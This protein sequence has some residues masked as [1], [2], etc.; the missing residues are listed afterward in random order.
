MKRL[1]AVL[2]CFS[3]LLCVTSCEEK[4]PSNANKSF[5]Y[6]LDAEPKTLDPQ[7]AND[8]SGTI[9]IQALFEGLTRLDADGNPTPGVAESW[10]SNHTFTEFTF[11][12]RQDAVWNDKEKTPVTADDFVYAFRRALDP[13]TGSTTSDPLLC[14]QNARAVRSGELP[15]EQLGVTAAGTHK[16]VVTL[17]YPYEDFPK[18]TASAV[19]MPCHEPFFESTKGRYG[20]EKS[21]LLGNGPFAIDGIYGWEHGSYINLRRFSGY[22]GDIKPLPSDIKFS[23]GSKKADVSDPIAALKDGTVDAI[24]MPAER[25]EEAREMGCTITRFEDT[26]WG[27]CFN[28]QNALMRNLNIRK[29]FT[30]SF[31]RAK[32]LSHLPAGTT[33]AEN[34][35]T[36][37]TKLFGKNYRE[38]AGSA[39][40]LQ[41]D[42]QAA[43]FLAAGIREL[44][45]ETL[46]K[47]TILCPDD[48]EVRL[49]VNEMLTEWNA[50]FDYYFNMESLSKKE[51]ASRIASGNYQLAICSITPDA[52][53]PLAVLNLF[54]SSSQNNPAGLRSAGYDEHLS[55]AEHQ[56]G[57]EAAAT[58]AAMERYLNEQCI[59]YPLYYESH[60][61]ASAPGVTGIVFHP[62]GGGVDFI[63]AGKG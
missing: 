19:C 5:Q 15:L 16:L 33:A 52:E 35:I 11:T 21:T 55:A 60:Y 56:N 51:L 40:Y 30:Q 3:L 39:F 31:D 29:A 14:I 57:A 1:A 63:S 13:A 12:L 44:G 10:T 41:Q 25:V 17:A 45:L 7:I 59:F 37:D 49:M 8:T 61:F 18:L 48:P 34:I 53:G 38:Q 36:P 27:L 42:N 62:Y 6:H 2:L 23:I 20:L 24:A 4:A 46:P 50:Q 9:L 47:V 58:C 32:V 28:T 54:K 26:T 22:S 43:Q